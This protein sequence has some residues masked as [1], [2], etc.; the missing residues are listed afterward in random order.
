MSAAQLTIIECQV[1]QLQG[2]LRGRVPQ[3][4]GEAGVSS[5]RHHTATL[6]PQPWPQVKNGRTLLAGLQK[7]TVSRVGW[8]L[9]QLILL[10]V[11]GMAYFSK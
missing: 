11:Q 8:T 3:P 5:R 9:K 6:A 10:L 7:H 4:G 1:Q 2:P